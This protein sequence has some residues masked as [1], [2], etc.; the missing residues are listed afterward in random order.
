[1]HPYSV[2]K[3]SGFNFMTKCVVPSSDEVVGCGFFFLFLLL[4]DYYLHSWSRGCPEESHSLHLED[5]LKSCC[6]LMFN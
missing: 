5:S 2:S 4:P 1:M 6:L 3:L